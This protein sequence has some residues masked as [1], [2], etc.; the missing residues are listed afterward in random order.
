ME[1]RIWKTK[2]TVSG[3]QKMYRKWSDYKEG[4]MLVGKYVDDHMDQY[5][6]NCP[7]IEVIEATTKDRTFQKDVIGK[8]LV[9]NHSGM[10][11]VAFDKVKKG[12]IVQLEYQGTS[13]IEK[14]K[15]AGKEAHVVKVEVV[16][17]GDDTT[18]ADTEEDFEEDHTSL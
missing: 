3:I 13:T 4:D 11:G 18:A 9:L 2:R 12:E 5:D 1:K 7:V 14:G 6:K 16:G 10:I 15:F 17:D 8:N